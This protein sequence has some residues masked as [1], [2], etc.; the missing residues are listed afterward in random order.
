LLI[1]VGGCASSPKDR[2]SPAASSPAGVHQLLQLCN[3]Q[4]NEGKP[5]PGVSFGMFL[6]QLKVSV[7]DVVPLLESS[8]FDRPLVEQADQAKSSW[9]R[10]RLLADSRLHDKWRR[11]GEVTLLADPGRAARL[12]GIDQ[13]WA[14]NVPVG[15]ECVVV[16]ELSFVPLAGLRYSRWIAV[17]PP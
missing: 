14:A 12:H 13:E 16:V 1:M 10:C 8:P 4:A 7:E 9:V 6:E 2:S 11:G 17:V 5:I 15:E 3:A